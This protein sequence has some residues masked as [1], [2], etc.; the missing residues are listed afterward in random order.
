MLVGHAPFRDDDRMKIY[1]KILYGT[2][3]LQFP[4]HISPIAIDLM[5]RL[6]HRNP[7][8]RLGGGGW[9]CGRRPTTSGTAH[10]HHGV[11]AIKCHDWFRGFDWMA[12]A[13]G[14]LVPPYVPVVRSCEDLSNFDDWDAVV[15]ERE[16][17]ESD[18]RE[19]DPILNWDAEF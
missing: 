13:D 17:V 10:I 3:H 7:R 15:E 1:A 12:L 9:S 8:K 5:K 19:G 14:T 18:E 2:S 16:S 11:H 4:S 6:M